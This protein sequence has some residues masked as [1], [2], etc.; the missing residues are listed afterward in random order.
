MKVAIL[1]CGPTGLASAHA[2]AMSG[3]DFHI[4][5]KKRKSFL[6]G[7]QYLHE[8]IPGISDQA[9]GTPIKYV[10]VGSPEEYRFK[11]HG[12][13]WD[14][15]VSPDDFQPHDKGWDIRQAYDALWRNYGREVQDYNIPKPPIGSQTSVGHVNY[16]HALAELQLNMYDLVI[17]TVPRT[18]WALR[19]D[20]FVSSKGWAIGDAPEHGKF[21][22]FTTEMDNMI[23]CNGSEGVAWTR[24]SRVFDYTT[25]EWP[26]GKR[27]PLEEVSEIIKPLRFEA[28]PLRAPENWM[29]VGRYGKWN[30]GE[31]VTD[32]Y[33]EVLYTLATHEMKKETA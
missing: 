32:A 12:A 15:V 30:K 5:S 11:V 21:A 2:C 31:L 18:F 3:V 33:N 24:L 9:I 6:F 28:G 26:E 8:R 13:A 20:K 10:T 23:V 19:G 14:G 16:D 7:S 25:I 4:F 1:G 17:S 27:P 29:F 22:P